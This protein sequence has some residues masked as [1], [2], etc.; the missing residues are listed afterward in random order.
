MAGSI[1]DR[2][3]GKYK[4]SYMKNK[5]RYNTT[6]T[7]TNMEEAQELLDKFVNSVNKLSTIDIRTCTLSEFVDLYFENY[8]YEMLAEECSY[9]Y[10]KTL[11][12]W[13]LPKIGDTLLIECTSE[14]FIK[15]FEWLSKQ[16]SPKTH[17][18]LSVGSKEK[19]FGVISSVFRCAVSWKLFTTNP[20][21]EARPDEFKRKA[22]TKVANVQSR[23]LTMEESRRLIKALNSVD[24]KYQIIVHLAIIGGLR[25]SEILGIKWQNINFKNRSLDIKQSSQYVPQKGYVE[26]DLKNETSERTIALPQSTI[27]MLLDY[28]MQVSGYDNDFVFINDK[29]RRKGLRMNPISV[30]AWFKRFRESIQLP[31]EV[32][33]HG[34]RHTN[35][36]I[37]I[38]TGINVKNVSS[39]LGHSNIGT[40]LNVYSHALTSVDK[41]AGNTLDKILFKRKNNKFKIQKKKKEDVLE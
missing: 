12:N 19:I 32:P 29:G 10:R 21:Y 15:Y 27:L 38:T 28:K 9:N 2:G 17:K 8:A 40:T 13:V 4:L 33:L 39:R 41:V 30:T 3:N 31:P 5:E 24:L 37:L 6:I 11:D 23:C 16:I 14:F 34:L 18:L 25:R 22:K 7:A 1:L 35:A 26:G 36:T 20:L